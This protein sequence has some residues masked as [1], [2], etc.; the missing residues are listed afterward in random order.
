[1]SRVSEWV[2]AINTAKAD[3]EE[4]RQ[5]IVDLEANPPSALCLKP[6]N[7]PDVQ[8]RVLTDGGMRFATD[9]KE[10]KGFAISKGDVEV[11]VG[12]VVTNFLD[13]NSPA[14]QDYMKALEAG[15]DGA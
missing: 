4:A 2:D 7:W 15:K 6:T 8:L 5:R 1:M 13:K 12:W 14:F 11:L 9:V 3:K 10:N